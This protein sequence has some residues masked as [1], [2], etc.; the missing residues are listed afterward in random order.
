MSTPSEH[1]KS[2]LIEDIK[3]AMTT[4]FLEL[5]NIL[6]FIYV[7]INQSISVIGFIKV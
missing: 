1:R 6:T 5:N 7:Q 4:Q 2:E 3:R